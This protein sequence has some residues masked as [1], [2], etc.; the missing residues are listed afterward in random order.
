VSH[1]CCCRISASVVFDGY[2]M[3]PPVFRTSF[4]RLLASRFVTMNP[5]RGNNSPEWNSTLVTTTRDPWKSTF[6]E[7]LKES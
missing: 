5:T 3:D 7:A 6:R 1:P 4:A 2:R